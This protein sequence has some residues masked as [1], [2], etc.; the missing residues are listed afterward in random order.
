MYKDFVDTIKD[1]AF[2]VNPNGTFYHGRVS[3]ANLA[4]EKQPTPQIHLYP[5]KVTRPDG[6]QAID[7]YT[8]LLAF[9]FQDTPHTS[10]EDRLEI[11]DNADIMQRR[12]EQW[13]I[14]KNVNY[15]GYEAEPYFKQFNGITS[16]MFVRFTA[17]VKTKIVDCEPTPIPEPEPPIPPTPDCNDI[18]FGYKATC[19]TLATVPE[20]WVN[21]AFG[22]TGVSIGQILQFKQFDYEN[23]L[24]DWGYDVGYGDGIRSYPSGKPIIFGSYIVDKEV[25]V[26]C[27]PLLDTI[28]IALFSRLTDSAIIPSIDG[29]LPTSLNYFKISCNSLVSIDNIL[30]QLDDNGVENG[31]AEFITSVPITGYNQILVDSLIAKGWTINIS[32]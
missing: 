21:F 11:I 24:I 27:N 9:I 19:G 14:A 2:E 20:G 30:Q 32:V 12:F 8:I 13:L 3:D 1:I 10:D 31:T 25:N 16:G 7:T 5:F 22:L 17:K 18:N 4:I 29:T 15:S 23:T 6:N 26:Y 28:E